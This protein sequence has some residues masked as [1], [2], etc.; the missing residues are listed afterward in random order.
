ML[1]G[2]DMIKA[3]FV[4]IFQKFVES[5]RKG[6]RLCGTTTTDNDVE[7]D[8]RRIDYG[9]VEFGLVQHLAISRCSQKL[10]YRH[11]RIPS[12]QR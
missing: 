8:G 9:I 2:N 7:Q 1:P 3:I 12:K 4:G 11:R 10:I 5:R 6:H